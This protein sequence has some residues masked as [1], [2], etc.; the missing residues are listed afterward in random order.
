[1]GPAVAGGLIGLAGDI[2]GGVFG[3]SSAK[4]AADVAWHRQRKFYKHRYQWQMKD[5]RKAGLNPILSAG[6]A[7]GTGGVPV[8]DTSAI[9]TAIGRASAKAAQMAQMVADVKLTKATTAKTVN[10]TKLL[11]ERIATEKVARSKLQDEAEITAWDRHQR[12]KAVVASIKRGDDLNLTPRQVADL[13]EAVSRKDYNNAR[14]ALARAGLPLAIFEGK[15]Y[16]KALEVAKWVL[17]SVITRRG[18]KPA[19]KNAPRGGPRALR[20]GR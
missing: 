10:D 11:G 19:F 14:A 16:G 5:M 4:K 3:A 12:Y 6:G 20:K 8:A 15:G 17:Q 13:E 2:F 7:P 9:P 1:M 18:G